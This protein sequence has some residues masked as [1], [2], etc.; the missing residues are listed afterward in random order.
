MGVVA[1]I[2]ITRLYKHTRTNVWQ[3][4]HMNRLH[5]YVTVDMFG[6][7]YL[8]LAFIEGASIWQLIKSNA[9]RTLCSL[10]T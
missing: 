10:V 1:V 3:P 7:Y 8:A 2:Q 6:N 5:V 9:G 4:F